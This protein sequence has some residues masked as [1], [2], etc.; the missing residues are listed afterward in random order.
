MVVVLLAAISVGAWVLAPAYDRAA[1]Q[2]VLTDRL[3]AAPANATALHL[4]AEPVAGESA[5]VGDTAAARVELTK[6]LNARP[7]LE[8]LLKEPVGGA[9]VDTVARAGTIE[10]LALLAYRDR[11]CAHLTFT[12]GE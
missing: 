10:V 11:V 6:D 12:D 2:S 7:T 4:L 8:S 9:D 3:D 1:Q 5:S